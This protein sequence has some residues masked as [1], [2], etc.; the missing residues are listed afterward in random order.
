MCLV[1]NSLLTNYE[2]SRELS[3]RMCQTGMAIPTRPCGARGALW[4]GYTWGNLSNCKRG[5]RLSL[6]PIGRNLWQS[7][8]YKLELTFLK[9]CSDFL[10]SHQRKCDCAWPV[11]QNGDSN[12]CRV[13][14][15][16]YSHAYG[17]KRS[18]ILTGLVGIDLVWLWMGI[19]LGET[20]QVVR[21]HCFEICHEL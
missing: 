4:Y 18:M 16:H 5:M 15:Y 2:G 10:A 21:Q 6:Y 9:V 13:Y 3:C 1:W 11:W 17:Y 20:C 7:R 12:L 8:T 14:T 19:S